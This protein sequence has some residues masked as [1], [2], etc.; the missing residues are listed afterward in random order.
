MFCLNKDQKNNKI[1]TSLLNDASGCLGMIPK[2]VSL[3]FSAHSL[4]STNDNSRTID[5]PQQRDFLTL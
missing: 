2:C 5:E 3:F 4:Q 1:K